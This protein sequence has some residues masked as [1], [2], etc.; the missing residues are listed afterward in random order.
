LIIVP[1]VKIPIALSV[2]KRTEST[3]LMLFTAVLSGLARTILILA[4]ILSGLTHR[5]LFISL[6]LIEQH[7]A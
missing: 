5:T 6:G 4:A 1:V 7:T 3:V 2:T